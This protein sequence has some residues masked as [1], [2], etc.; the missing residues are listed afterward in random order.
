VEILEGHRR[1]AST[2]FSF[3]LSFCENRLWFFIFIDFIFLSLFGELNCWAIHLTYHWADCLWINLKQINRINEVENIIQLT[4]FSGWVCSLFGPDLLE[5]FWSRRLVAILGADTL[6]SRCVQWN[7]QHP[8]KKFINLNE[9]RIYRNGHV[10]GAA[11]CSL[12][13]CGIIEILDIAYY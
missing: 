4:S 2:V 3:F 6:V 11:E 5:E 13:P 12:R 10:L 8:S 1:F 9:P 7:R